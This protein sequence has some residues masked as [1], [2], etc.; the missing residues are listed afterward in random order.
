MCIINRPRHSPTPLHCCRYQAKDHDGDD[1]L[2]LLSLSNVMVVPRAPQPRPKYQESHGITFISPIHDYMYST[3]V[4]SNSC[5]LF[6][7]FLGLLLSGPKHRVVACG[8][9]HERY[10]FAG[11]GN[12]ISHQLCLSHLITIAEQLI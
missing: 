1:E 3:E 5:I 11:G 10:W 9:C 7:S 2:D 6:S 12:Q 4:A 8:A